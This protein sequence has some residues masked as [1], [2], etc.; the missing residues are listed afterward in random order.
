VGARR[1]EVWDLVPSYCGL[2]ASA[3]ERRTLVA[4]AAFVDDSGRNDPPVFVLA[5]LMARPDQWAR[6]TDAWNEVL[7]IPPGLDYFKMQEAFTLNGQFGREKGWT[8]PLRDE[9]VE[10]LAE[11]TRA[12]SMAAFSAVVLHEEYQVHLSGQVDRLIDHPYFLMYGNVIYSAIKWQVDNGMN[13]PIDF[14]FDDQLRDSTE[15]IAKFG[16]MF[17]RAPDFVKSRI[18]NR[19]TWGND[20]DHK[21]LQAADLLA[22]H[23]RR[24]FYEQRR[25]LIF[26]TPAAR[27]L[28]KIPY[29][30]TFETDALLRY[31][32][33]RLREI[34]AETGALFPYEWDAI[35]RD[36]DKILSY[37]NNEKIVNARAGDLVE[38]ISIPASGMKRF[39]MMYKCQNVRSPHLHRRS[40]NVCLGTSLSSPSDDPVQR[41]KE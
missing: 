16:D 17:T 1:C 37:S 18:K 2:P 34:N 21:P 23:I 28:R 35:V 39:Q 25:G 24:G 30:E 19:P 29:E 10:A 40:G 36:M 38:L 6:F 4:L 5:G 33:G 22:W 9:R 26:D 12:Y 20:K 41:Q 27:I 11:L 13:E 14:I 15:I 3:L 8:E 32:A 7:A 31:S